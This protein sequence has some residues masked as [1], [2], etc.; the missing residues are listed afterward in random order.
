[1][2]ARKRGTNGV[3][4]QAHA[5]KGAAA[6]VAAESLHAIG[7]A[8]EYAGSNRQLDCWGEILPRAVEEFDQFKKNLESDGWI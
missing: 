5:I 1:M 3:S 6:I 2:A 7:R 8:M 4:A